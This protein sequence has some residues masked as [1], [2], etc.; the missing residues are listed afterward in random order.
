M[1]PLKE[2]QALTGY[3]RGGVTALACKKDYRGVY[4]RACGNLR[5]DLGVCRHTKV[6]DPASPA[7]YIRAVKAKLSS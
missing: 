4:R 1:L 6:A 7:D 5:R 2:V 3:I